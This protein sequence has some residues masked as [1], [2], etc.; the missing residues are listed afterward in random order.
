M[1]FCRQL[2]HSTESTILTNRSNRNITNEDSICILILSSNQGM[3]LSSHSLHRSFIY[4]SYWQIIYC[5]SLEY[6]VS[7]TGDMKYP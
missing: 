5:H 1:I 4:G 2:F 3:G 6:S 7:E